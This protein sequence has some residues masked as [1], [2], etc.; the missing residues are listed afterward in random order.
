MIQTT[1]LTGQELDG[2]QALFMATS[3]YQNQ[4][5]HLTRTG[6]KGEQSPVCL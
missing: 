5:N 4:L 2:Y 1:G 6:E 3:A